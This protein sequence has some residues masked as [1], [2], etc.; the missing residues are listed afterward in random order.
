MQDGSY[1]KVLKRWGLSDEAVAKSE[2]NPPGLPK[3]KN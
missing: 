1:A 2:I 3:P